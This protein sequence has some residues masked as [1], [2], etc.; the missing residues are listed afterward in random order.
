MIDAPGIFRID[1]ASYLADPCREPSISSGCAFRLLNENPFA[2]WYFHPRLGGHQREPSAASDIGT[3]AHDILLGGEGKIAEINP[4]DYRSKPTKDN[5]EGN[6]PNGWVNGAIRAARDEARD[7]G[8]TPILSGDMIGVRAMV[9]A[10]REYVANSAIRGV[11]DSG[12]SELTVI[13]KKGDTWLRARPD[14]LNDDICLHYK[15]SKADIGPKSFG[16]IMGSMGYSFA[17]AYYDHILKRVEPTS[18]RHQMILVQSQNPP[19]A[20]A[21]Y[22]LAPAKLAIERAQVS[23]AIALWQECIDRNSWPGYSQR[24]CS[25]DVTP[26]ELAEHEAQLVEDEMKAMEV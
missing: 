9:K 13:A 24:V 25:I 26:W 4:A 11:F 14:W 20:C 6:I 18:M 5:P 22:D 23:R 10:A 17:L 2:A 12:E 3:I 15:T 19:Y 8:L 21:L 16:R 1:M 7:N